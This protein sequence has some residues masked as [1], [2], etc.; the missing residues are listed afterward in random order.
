MRSMVKNAAKLAVY[1]EIMI[2][3]KN[4]QALPTIRPAKDLQI[5]ITICP[6]LYRI[7]TSIIKREN[8]LKFRAQSTSA[9]D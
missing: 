1:D 2:S 9:S 6:A 8:T 7:N 3:V 4:H 5:N